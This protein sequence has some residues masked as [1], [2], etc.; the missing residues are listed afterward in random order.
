MANYFQGEFPHK[1]S[2]EEG[3]PGIAPVGQF[4]PNGYGLHDIT[5]NCWEWCSDWYRPDYFERCLAM[6]IVRNPRGPAD[7][8]DPQEP[9]QPKRV[10]RGGSFLCAESYCARFQAGTRDKGE[11]STS[12]NHL[13]FRCVKDPP[14]RE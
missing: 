7:S 10:H 1:D 4:P 8:Y 11:P 13:S 3:F 2:A 9:N 14:G 6:K 5:G 12:S